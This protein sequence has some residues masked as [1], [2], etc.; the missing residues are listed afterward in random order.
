MRHEPKGNKMET[1]K[2][3]IQIKIETIEG[4]NE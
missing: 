1:Q 3:T 2:T 4:G